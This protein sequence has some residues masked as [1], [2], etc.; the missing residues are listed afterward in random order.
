M[1]IRVKEDSYREHKSCI[2]PKYYRQIE[3]RV[4]E[5][6]RFKWF[7][8][9][10]TEIGH[11]YSVGFEAVCEIFGQ[12]NCDKQRLR[13]H[14]AGKSYCRWKSIEDLILKNYY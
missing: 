10:L 6:G 9:E 7:E 12:V 14:L 2:V 13:D 1:T 8:I 3:R 5:A 11:E 4:D